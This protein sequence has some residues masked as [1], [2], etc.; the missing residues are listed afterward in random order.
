MALSGIVHALG[1]SLSAI[2]SQSTAQA[3]FTPDVAGLQVN[4]ESSC[5]KISGSGFGV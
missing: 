2:H 3:H 1:L 4:N 5:L